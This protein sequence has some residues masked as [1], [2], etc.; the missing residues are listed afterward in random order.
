MDSSL[1]DVKRRWVAQASPSLPD[2]YANIIDVQ[3]D[4]EMVSSP[5]TRDVGL[6]RRGPRALFR[7]SGHWSTA[8]HGQGYCEGIESRTM[9]KLELLSIILSIATVGIALGAVVIGSN[10][11]LRTELRTEMES[12]RMDT[13][14]EVQGLRTEIENLR[15]DTRTEM[16]ELRTEMRAEIQSLRTDV[17]ADFAEVRADLRAV[18]DRLSALEQRQARTEGLVEA[19]RDAIATQGLP[20]AGGENEAT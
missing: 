15:A 5:V 3:N 9:K 7:A 4:K 8:E 14:A 16:Q 10:A 11:T 1:I 6:Q 20:D 13:R 12:L 2:V 17:R 19:L 18:E